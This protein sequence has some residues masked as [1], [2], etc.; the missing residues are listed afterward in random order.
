M[1]INGGV[2]RQNRGQFQEYWSHGIVQTAFLFRKGRE[3][4]IKTL[5][6]KQVSELPRKN[7]NKS[8]CKL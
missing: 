7:E 3:K 4:C 1:E 2:S 6:T 5:F 8:I